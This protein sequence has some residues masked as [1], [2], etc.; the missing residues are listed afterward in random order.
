LAGVA[1][2]LWLQKKRLLL[3][4][5]LLAALISLL[6]L[7]REMVIHLDREKK[8]QSLVERFYLWERALQ[9]IEARPWTGTG[10]NTYDVA[11]EKYDR[12]KNWRVRGYYAHN[13]YLQIAAE[14]GLPSLA[15]FV[16]FLFFYFRNALRFLVVLSAEQKGSLIG[17]LAGMV[18]FLILGT[19]DTIF[20]NPQSVMGFWFLAGW[21]AAIT[22][23]RS[24][25]AGARG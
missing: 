15:F 3:A 6:F 22:S 20:H 19:N 13:G 25:E 8:E 24:I 12:R 7:P 16:A 11:H 2:F 18:S 5:L 4:G 9:V 17:I 14:T 21:G 1:F 23:V 10:I